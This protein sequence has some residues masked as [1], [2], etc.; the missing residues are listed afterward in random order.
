MTIQE[1]RTYLLRLTNRVEQCLRITNRRHV[2]SIFINRLKKLF[3]YRQ[4]YARF[5][6]LTKIKKIASQIKIR[7]F[8]G[9]EFLM[10]FSKGAGIYY[11]GSLDLEEQ[12]SIKFLI[13]HLQSDDIFYDIGAHWGFYSSLAQELIDSGEIHAFEPSPQIFTY[14]EK[15]LT[16]NAST[17]LINKAVSDTAS[18]VTFY[19]GEIAESG[20]STLIKEVALKNISYFKKIDILAI[21][22]DEYICHYKAPTVLKIDAEGAESAIIKGG[23]H[24]FKK[25]RPLVLMEVWRGEKGQQ[26][27]KQAVD[28]LIQLGYKMYWINNVGEL[29]PIT[30][31]KIEQDTYYELGANFV[32]KK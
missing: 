27:S 12:P 19:D 17:F 20:S 5:I 25:N 18:Q 16:K 10:P 7:T 14:L 4:K 15:N 29:L 21:S 9:R 3:Y 1:K 8:W 24:F 23:V 2:G 30:W 26:F 11:F 31:I 13:K 32:F 22:L 6:W 28:Q